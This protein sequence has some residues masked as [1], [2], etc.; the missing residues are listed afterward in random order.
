MEVS[1]SPDEKIYF[2]I[3]LNEKNL[4]NPL[5]VSYNNK[6]IDLFSVNCNKKV[7][8]PLFIKY[9]NRGQEQMEDKEKE[10]QGK[11]NQMNS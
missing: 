7:W 9:K 8:Y 4:N 2:E 1:E 3:F 11:K 10:K 5:L 6:G